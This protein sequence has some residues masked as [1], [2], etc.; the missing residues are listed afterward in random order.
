MNKQKLYDAYTGILR[1]ELQTAMGCT[2][3]I[4]IAYCAAL[5]AQTLG[6]PPERYVARCSGNIIKN[7]KSV[8]VPQTGGLRGIEAAVL[9]GAVGGDPGRRL[10]VLAG[11]G[12]AQRAQIRK[13]L[14]AHAVEVQLLD[15]PHALH[16]IVECRAGAQSASAEIIDAHTNVGAVYKNGELLHAA[17]PAAQTSAQDERELLNVRDILAY[18]REVPLAS[19]RDVLERQIECNSAI[20]AEGLRG[21]WGACVGKTLLRSEDTPRTRLK[22]VAAAGSD[23]RMSG[24]PLPVVINSG[25]GNQGMAA[26]LPVIEYARQKG[27]PHEML[28]RALCVS[29]LLSVHQKTG[30]GKLS[31]FCG[32]TSAATGSA[33][34]IAFLD[35][36]DYDCITKTIEN[37]LA[38]VGGMLCDG[39]KASCGAKIATALECALTGYEMAKSGEGFRCGEGIVKSDVEQTIETVGRIASEG[40][41]GTDQVILETML[42]Q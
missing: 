7:T 16:I 38:T 42:E 27:I 31:A 14:A 19:V 8:T 23:A 15:T 29:N 13:Q 25:S 12:D 2:E 26:S 36:Q 18:A 17:L 30:I 9:A 6:C 39:A 40:M 28:L 11:V 4:A 20:A 34:A 33:A 1:E 35:G 32:A 10:E 21:D 37:S 24:C 22:A 3:P 41:K 5:A